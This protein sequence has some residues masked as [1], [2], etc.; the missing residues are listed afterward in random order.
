[1]PI[2]LITVLSLVL[3]TGASGVEYVPGVDSLPQE[4]VPRG[5]VTKHTW[6]ASRIYPDATHEYWVYVPDQYADTEPACLMVFQDGQAY[7]HLNGPVRAPTVFD[8]LIHKGEMPV[9]IGIFINPG[10]KRTPLRPT[11]SAVCS[12][13]RRLCALPAGRNPPGGRQGLQPRWR[14]RGK[15]HLR[16]ERWRA[17]PPS[18]SPGNAPTPSA[19]SSV[20]WVAIRGFVAVPNIR[21]SFE[22][23]AETQNPYACFCRMD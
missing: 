19:R 12:A 9:T 2:L 14:C 13:G 3:A 22:G 4:G 1:M 21:F 16:H 6:D 7:V 8:N 10:R 5:T 17:V 15:S 23:P 11:S 18:P 20:T